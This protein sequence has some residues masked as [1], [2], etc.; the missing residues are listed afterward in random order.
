MRQSSNLRKLASFLTVIM[1]PLASLAMKAGAQSAASAF[2]VDDMLDVV[3]VNV[4]DL[5]EDGRWV[6]VTAGTLRDRIGID[7]HRFGDP[8]YIAP[9]A[10]EVLIIDTQ[11]AKTQKLFP[12]KRQVRGLRWSPDASKLALFVIK[13]DRF[14][15]AIW[16][17]ATG[18]MIDIKLPPGKQAADNAEL[19]WSPDGASLLLA[20]RGEGWRKKAAEQFQHETNGPVVVHSSKEPFLAWDD[21][22]RM[23][24][25]RS[26]AAYDVK[27]G[28]TRELLPETKLN[29]YDLSDDG[30]FIS[31][32]E[33]IT[34]KTDYD[35][36]FGSENH[37]QVVPASGGAAR[38][39]IKST[40]GLTVTWSK[41]GRRYAYSKE[42]SVWIGSVD[43]KEPRQLI[44]K[45]PDEKDKP[46]AS[47]DKTK[48]DAEKERKE[49]EKERF[50]VVR[51]SPKEVGS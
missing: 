33:D 7:N 42:G 21:L 35:V 46:E 26:L 3:S 31:Y 23:S 9:N 1:L 30:S 11:T 8:T 48:D 49:K 43:D 2:N 47:A 51:L 10:V 22:R 44:G 40:K 32:Q 25:L 28:Q 50:T 15:P 41:D 6:A 45:K 39:V 14:E 20:L 27:S 19:E 38:T 29:S 34:K 36:I 18:K 12:G 13:G 37:I 4:A 5:S 16:E 24:A 17:R